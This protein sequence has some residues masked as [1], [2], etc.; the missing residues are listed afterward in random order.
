MATIPGSQ[1]LLNISGN[2]IATAVS[3]EAGGTL[4]DGGGLSGSSNQVLISTGT[5]VDWVDGSGSG[6]IGGPYLPLAGGTMTGNLTVDGGS[7]TVDP[8]AAGAVFTWKES[9]GTTVAGQLRGYANRGDIYLYSDGTK[10]TEISA[11]SDSFIPALHIGGTSA[12]SGGVLQVTG[13]A[14]ATTFSG[15]LNGTINTVTTAVTK[16]NA[17]NDTTVATTAFVQNLIGT[18]P[19]G[20]VFQGTWNAATN[21]PTLTSGSGTTGHFYIVST[22]GSTNL[23]GVTDW[24]TGDWAVFIEQG[25][26][27]AWEKIDNSSVLDGSGTGNTVPLWAGSGTSNTLGNSIITQTGASPNQIIRITSNAD[28]Q[29]RLDGAATSYA[30]IHWVDN[31]GGDYMWFNGSTSTFAIGGGGSAVSGKKLHIDGSTSIGSNYDAVSPPTNGLVVEGSVG[32]GTDSP[33]TTLDL[34]GDYRQTYSPV[35]AAGGTPI[36][37]TLSYSV[38]PYGLVTRA[39]N[40]GLYSIQNEREANAGETFDLSLQ[41]TGGKTG[42]G[43]T[44]PSATLH[45][46]K[47]TGNTY[48]TP[49]TNADVFIVENKNAGTGVGGGMTI[50]ADNGASGNIY[51]GDEQ[52]NQVAGIT[53]DN[54]SSQTDLFFTTNGNNERLR[55]KGNGNVGI[56]TDSPDT[57]LNLEGVKNKSIITL[58]ST[59]NDSG[60]AVGDKIGG[61]DFYSADGSGA[62]SGVKGSISYIASTAGSGGVTAMTFSTAS[63]VSNNVERMRIDTSG[64]VGIGTIG[65]SSP[66]TV[67]TSGTT[68]VAYFNNTNQNGNGVLIH[69]ANGGAGVNYILRLTSGTSSVPKV[70]V[71][72]NGSVGINIAAPT[73]KLHVAGNMRLENQLFDS[74][75]SQ[76]NSGQVLT[77]ISQGTSWADANIGSITGV[78]AGDGLTGGGTTGS[79]TLDVVGGTGITANANDISIDSTVITTTGSQTIT[80]AKRFNG[81]ILDAGGS[82]G[83]GGQV[84]ASTGTG[85]VDWVAAASGTIAGTAADTRIAFGSAANTLTSDS[86]FEVV[87][88]VSGGKR[89]KVENGG[90]QVANMTVGASSTTVGSIRY[91]AVTG[92]KNQSFMDIVMQ[93]GGTVG[94]AGGTYAWVNIVSNTWNP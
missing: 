31:N 27:D 72:E 39:Y 54:F 83:T 58:G 46:V 80:G 81:S 66:L 47:G 86:D 48:P 10:T 29:L 60:W 17:T 38:S 50:F 20:L 32:I 69:A 26:T 87:T 89:I 22:S 6:I 53:C 11:I 24:V 18:I 49:S 9:D 88:S 90:I 70:T 62:G 84:L 33:S 78:V 68:P 15:D 77:K 94:A 43:T 28:A 25:G 8:D 36:A 73:Q 40:N 5:G 85:Q 35:P 57:L 7:I 79:V 71:V 41:P 63:S 65:P 37:R 30:G 21:T 51:F 1:R 91:R 23:D 44:S 2:N 12:A 59:T 3:L 34:L 13:T 16:A 82:S 61:I 92:V 56:G 45:V 42:I 75:N 14:T 4:L 74:N 67:E 93:T 76:G 19:A 55:I 52:S 64:N